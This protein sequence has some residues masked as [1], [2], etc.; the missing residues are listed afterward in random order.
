MIC[1]D[2]RCKK[3]VNIQGPSTVLRALHN[4][5]VAYTEYGLDPNQSLRMMN[6]VK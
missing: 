3:T 5:C 4:V 1:T 2:I 6:K